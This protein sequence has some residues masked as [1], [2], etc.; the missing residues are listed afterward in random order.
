MR[1]NENQIRKIVSESLKKVL[2]EGTSDEEVIRKWNY[3]RDTAGAEYMLDNIMCYLNCEMV[4]KIV[5]WFEQDG[6]LEGY[7]ELGEF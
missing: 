1:I 4:E 3:I 7:D 5:G 6:Y 2:N